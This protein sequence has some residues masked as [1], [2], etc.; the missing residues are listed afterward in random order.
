MAKRFLRMRMKPCA[1]GLTLHQRGAPMTVIVAIYQLRETCRGKPSCSEMSHRYK[2]SKAQSSAANLIDI[3]RIGVR[4]PT[5]ISTIDVV[6]P[7]G[8]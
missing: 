1:V 6:R 2:R 5:E 7:C 4:D 3:G 8:M